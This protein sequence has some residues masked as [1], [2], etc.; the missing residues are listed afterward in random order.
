[1]KFKKVKIIKKDGIEKPKKLGFQKELKKFFKF[2]VKNSVE[3]KLSGYNLERWLNL[4]TGK[5]IKFLGVKKINIKNS[6]I[7]I[8][9]KDEKFVCSFLKG[10]N[11]EIKDKKY[12]GLYKICRFFL[13]RHGIL[14]GLA[15]AFCFFVV[16]SNYVW[17]IEIM[18]NEKS[19]NQEIISTLNENG[20]SIFDAINETTN[21]EIEKIVLDNFDEVSMVSVVKKGTTI[22]INIKE[23]LLNDE[24]ENLGTHSALLAT[25]DGII[26]EIKLIQGTLLVKVGDTIRVGDA[27]VA[28]YVIDS[29]GHKISIQ[30]KAEIYADVWLSGESVHYNFTEKTERTGVVQIERKMTFLNKEI[31]THKNEMNFENYETEIKEEYLADYLLPI[32]YMTITYFE[33]KIEK[34]EQSFSEVEE[35]KVE[36]A[37][38]LA[39]MCMREGEQI[40]SQNYVITPANGKTT[41]SYVVVVNR[42]I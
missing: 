39:L 14:I 3:L 34:I 18:G 38:A 4:L 41:I 2:N 22:I 9:P 15:L 35:Q 30:P 23:K 40:K 20:V 1:M 16:A 28:P 29:S 42:I 32:K 19:T 12:H 5:G 27:L 17:N 25:N 37:K 6:E 36:E 33:T 10:K 21:E 11:V 8:E 26:T 7:E 24:H 31:F 13:A